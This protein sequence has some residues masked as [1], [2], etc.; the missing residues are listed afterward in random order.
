MK[1]AIVGSVSLAGSAEALRIINE[2]LDRYAPTIVMSG[3][4]EGHRFDGRSGG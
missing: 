3:G 1:L 4:A 2:V